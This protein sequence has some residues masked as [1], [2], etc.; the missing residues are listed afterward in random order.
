MPNGHRGEHAV[1]GLDGQT[2]TLVFDINAFCDVEDRLGVSIA[3]L[4]SALEK[5]S[6]R[7]LRAMFH[8]GLQARHPGLDERAVGAL[9]GLRE[10]GQA[11]TEAL[12]KAM[13][14]AS[15]DARPPAAPAGGSG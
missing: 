11:V 14:E 13:P 6:A 7:L 9:L 12:I 8:A 5:P 1:T 10:M 2:Y 15:G 3:D 4:E